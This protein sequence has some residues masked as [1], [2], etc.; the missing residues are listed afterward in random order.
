[1]FDKTPEWIASCQTYKGGFAALPGEYRL[2]D[3][4]DYHQ[5]HVI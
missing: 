2:H 3:P 1:M 4:R 5:D